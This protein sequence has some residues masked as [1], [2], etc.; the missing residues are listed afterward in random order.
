[1]ES[2]FLT[3]LSTV[4]DPVPAN[5]ADKQPL[6]SAKLTALEQELRRD[7]IAA[8]T[9]ATSQSAG[10]SQFG[11]EQ[12]RA[13]IEQFDPQ[14]TQFNA[15]GNQLANYDTLLKQMREDTLGSSRAMELSTLE[16][17]KETTRMS[18]DQNHFMML[19][20]Q[21]GLN[22]NADRSYRK[23]KKYSRMQAD[24]SWM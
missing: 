18:M 22:S 1:M 23:A 8:K 7:T 5:K 21:Y 13:M 12:Q 3:Q 11:T 24:E 16:S 6:N 2:L 17:A 14:N 4:F 15:Y 20:H 19:S 10:T 9:E